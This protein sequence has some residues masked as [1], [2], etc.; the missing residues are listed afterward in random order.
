MKVVHDFSSRFSYD[1]GASILQNFTFQ[2]KKT[3]IAHV[4]QSI[5]YI[6][7]T[8]TVPRNAVMWPVLFYICPH[9]DAD[10]GH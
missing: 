4:R 9:T 1:D 2:Q 6:V 5:Q 8:C 3:R 7:Y 10:C